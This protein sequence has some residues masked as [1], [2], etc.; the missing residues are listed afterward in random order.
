MKQHVKWFATALAV[1]SGLVMTG[2]AYSQAVT[3]TPYLSNLDPSTLN[4]APNALYSNWALS[5]TTF[6]STP[7]GLEV[8]SGG[9][10]SLYYVIPGANVQYP[11]NPLD[12]VATLTLTFNSP[13]SPP[14]NWIGVQFLLQDNAGSTPNLGGYGGYGNVGN[15]SNWVWT[16]N[17]LAIT[18][19]LPAAQITAIQAG[20]DAIYSFNLGIDGS[21]LGASTYDV[22]FNSLVISSVPEPASLALVGLGAA[23]LL[24]FRRRK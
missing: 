2:S 19:D 21:P 18:A 4:T 3:G 22:T 9:Y 17:Q 12:T 6:T 11:L 13:S 10:G 14:P 7:T 1:A 16:G 23:G 20:T 5:A 8:Y 24:A 15:P